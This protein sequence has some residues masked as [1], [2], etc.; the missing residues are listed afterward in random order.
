MR[1]SRTP[2]RGGSGTLLIGAGCLLMLAGCNKGGGEGNWL[3]NLMADLAPPTPTQ[4]ALDAFDVYDADKRRRA[5]ALLSAAPFGGEEPYL[6]LYRMI[7]GRESDGGMIAPDPDPTVRAV[8]TRAVGMHG[9]V[10]D[11]ELLVDMLDDNASFVRWEAAK[12]LQRVHNPVAIAALI[13]ATLH[14]EDVDVRMASAGALGQYAQP[15]VF[16]ALVGALDDNDYAVVRAAHASL[17][18]LTGHDEGDHTAAAWL[19]WAVQHRSDLFTDQ[20]TYTYQP[21]VKPPGL[22]QK[23]KFWQDTPPPPRYKPTGLELAQSDDSQPVGQEQ[24]TDMP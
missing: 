10:G 20:Q 6:N 1:N 15:N 4:A 24:A 23:L 8:A 5:I 21:Y 14:D 11:A 22:V 13:R 19:E 12:G 16:H 18:T 7:L 9:K 2:F 17:V 3:G